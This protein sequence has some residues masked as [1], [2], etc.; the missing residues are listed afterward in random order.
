MLILFIKWL[1]EL[2]VNDH[3]RKE[4]VII[5][6]YVTHADVH[7]SWWVA[8]TVCYRFRLQM[9]IKWTNIQ[10]HISLEAN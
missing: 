9:H 6:N 3:K 8:E 5:I 7:L 4:A 10:G 1:Y 2:I